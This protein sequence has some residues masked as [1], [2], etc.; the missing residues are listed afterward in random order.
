MYGS[1]SNNGSQNHSGQRGPQ[2]VCSTA[3]AHCRVISELRPGCLE[4]YPTETG[5]SPR[6]AMDSRVSRP[7]TC[8]CWAKCSWC[9]AS[10]CVLSKTLLFQFTAIISALSV[11]PIKGLSIELLQFW[12]QLPGALETLPRFLFTRPKLL[13][14][15]SPQLSAQPTSM[16]PDQ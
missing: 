1:Q 12:M 4:P 13:P 8:D 11:H 5:K 15:Q 2:E 7:N 16:Y 3:L 14:G 6:M 10:L 9:K